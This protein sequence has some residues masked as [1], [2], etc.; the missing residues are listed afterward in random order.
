MHDRRGGAKQPH[1]FDPARAALLDDKSRFEYLPPSAIV[2]L[3]DLDGIRTLLDFGTGTGMYA[4]EVA[5]AR[6]DRISALA[7]RRA[8]PRPR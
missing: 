6:S 3:L 7:A 2:A 4:I 8:C 5:R 1:P